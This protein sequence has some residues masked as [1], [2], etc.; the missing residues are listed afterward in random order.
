MVR[1]LRL[2]LL[3]P[4]CFQI[5]CYPRLFSPLSSHTPVL[6]LEFPWPQLIAVLYSQGSANLPPEALRAW[7]Q[8]RRVERELPL[9]PTT[10]L[11]QYSSLP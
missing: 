11:V 10:S 6:R 7:V 1:D 4:T 3:S 9:L 5:V 8:R 2:A